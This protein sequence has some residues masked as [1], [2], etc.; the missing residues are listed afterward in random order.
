SA[1]RF[2]LRLEPSSNVTIDLAV[3]GS[4]TRENSAPNVAL[5]INENA[6]AAQVWNA[7]YSGAAAICTNLSNPARLSDQRCFN[8]QWAVGPYRHGGTFTSI[9][10]VFT[11]GNPRKYQSG[12][13]VKIWGASGTV[14]WKIS[15]EIAVKSITAYRK[16]T[17]FWT[18]DSDHSPATIVETNSD[19][20]QDQ[21]SQELQLQGKMSNGKFNWVSGGYYSSSK[22]RNNGVTGFFFAPF[23]ASAPPYTAQTPVA[24]R[25]TVH[26]DA[27]TKSVFGAATSRSIESTSFESRQRLIEQEIGRDHSSRCRIAQAVRFGVER[28]G[29]GG[30]AREIGF[31][32]R[33]I[34]D[35]MIRIEKLR[36]VKIG[37]D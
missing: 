1:G 28:S 21:F 13:D 20:K 9:S 7:L 33:R 36:H 26:E 3:D 27:T 35:G 4:R 31:G 37:A 6:P 17:G 19:W 25:S 29:I 18:R 24:G 10:S 12:S 32:I 30:E 15:P 11:N 14:E 16:V 8:S 2:A 34:G 23:G 5:K 22:M